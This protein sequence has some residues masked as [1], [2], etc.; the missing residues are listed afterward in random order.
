MK[1]LW[2]EGLSASQIAK[3]LGDVT[4]NAVIGKVHRLGLEPRAKPQRKNIAVGQ[5]EGGILSVSYSGNLAFKETS[6]EDIEYTKNHDMLHSNIHSLDQGSDQF[7]V[8]I[9][10]LTENQCKWPQGDPGTEDFHFCGHQPL[11]GMPYCEHHAKKAYKK[12]KVKS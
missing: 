9:L 5:L 11:S 7:A 1:N 6:I 10:N 12:F 4:R 2:S 3:R 8:T